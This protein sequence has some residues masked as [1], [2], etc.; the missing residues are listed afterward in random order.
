MRI[1]LGIVLLALGGQTTNDSATIEGFVRRYGSLEP[2]PDAQ[3]TLTQSSIANASG[4]AT[5]DAQGRYSFRN[6]APGQHAV[7]VRRD[8]Y[9]GSGSL[10]NPTS[11]VSVNVT[12]EKQQR[13]TNLTLFLVPGGSISGRLLGPNNRVLPGVQVE[14][15]QLTYDR[16]GRRLVRPAK[17]AMSDDRG[18]YRLSGLAP[19]EYYV[20]ASGARGAAALAP[21]RFP[22]TNLQTYYPD[23]ADVL[24]STELKLKAGYEI[25]GIDIAVRRAPA[26]VSASGTI[27]NAIPE[28]LRGDTFTT[29]LYVVPRAQPVIENAAAARS[30]ITNIDSSRARFALQGVMPGEYHLYAVIRMETRSTAVASNPTT[31]IG[32]GVMDVRNGDVE[33][34]TVTVRPGIQ[35]RGRL[36]VNGEAP[37]G[38]VGQAQVGWVPS[39][40][41]PSMTGLVLVNRDSGEFVTDNIPPGSYRF[42]YGTIV[43][44][45]TYVL[46]ARIDGKSVWDNEIRIDDV[47]PGFLDVIVETPGGVVEGVVVD[48]QLKPVGGAGVAV[49]PE[50]RRQ[51]PAFYRFATTNTDG[52]FNIRGIAPGTYKVFAMETASTDTWMDP[53]FR[54]TYESRGT[55]ITIA[56]GSPQSLTL[57]LI[58]E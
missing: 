16:T 40:G 3:V 10:A 50:E 17:T 41:L 4:T 36:T 34:L 47:S 45:D 19:G 26:G 57:T 12:V 55:A 1:L 44:L 18:E 14:A 2:I 13:V 9:F 32:Y 30:S 46:D 56:V 38:R 20:R 8:G 42:N 43:P 11:S 21:P 49:V 22:L 58:P 28:S 24:S 15:V 5:T 54:T 29:T 48:G 39:D 37:K 35:I 23:T 53:V 33:N 6:V 52:R 27:I 51:T 31:F 7:V 25:V